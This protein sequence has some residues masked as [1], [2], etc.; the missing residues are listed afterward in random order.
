MPSLDLNSLVTQPLIEL[1]LCL[2]TLVF[3]G[4]GSLALV[5]WWHRSLAA[6]EKKALQRQRSALARAYRRLLYVWKRWRA[7]DLV[8]ALYELWRA[9]TAWKRGTIVGWIDTQLIRAILA[10]SGLVLG[11]DLFKLLGHLATHLSQ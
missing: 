1:S 10:V 8:A 5:I 4:L 6:A 11:W 2:V 3:G 7:R 9:Y